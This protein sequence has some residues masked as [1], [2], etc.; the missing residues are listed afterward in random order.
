MSAQQV[1][2]YSDSEYRGTSKTLGVGR[3]PTGFG[4]KNDSLSSLKIPS[5]LKVTLCEHDNFQGRRC[6]LVRDTPNLGGANDKA[7]SLI[8]EPVTSPSVI[9]Y[10][11]SDFRGWSAEV[12]VGSQ[13]AIGAGND[14]VSS[15][16]V[17][18]GYRVT[19]YEDGPFKGRTRE[20][21]ADA[22]NLG[23]F[24]DRTSSIVVDCL[25]DRSP[26]L[27]ELN[28]II[29]KVG[30]RIYLHPDDAFG[31]SSVEWFLKRATLH[32]RGGSSRSADSAP[33]P[34]GGGDD[35]A[36]WLECSR[37]AR[38]GDLGSAVAY[39]NAKYKDHW[40]DIQF[41]IFYPYNGAG[42]AEVT[43]V[44][45]DKTI[46]LE[47]MGQHGGDWEHVTC[48]V[49]P[50]S[51]ELRAMYLAQHS[52]GQWLAMGD[53]PREN[54]R[55][56]V[57]SSRHGHACYR[58]EGSNLSNG[59]SQKWSGVT[60]FEFGLVNS[61][62]KGSKLLD[63]GSKYQLLRA[64]FLTSPISAPDWINYCRRWGPHI[65]YKSSDL[66]GSI[67][68][69]LGDIPYSGEATDAIWDA[70]PDEAKEENGPTGPWRKGAWSGNE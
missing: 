53:I 34:A 1:T 46:K 11:D 4:L 42:K 65:T 64:D 29:K 33:L 9:V 45:V 17:P 10:S 66:K 30:P 51:Q 59:T 8:I 21:T 23:D 35:G 47:P 62:A 67:R 19:L 6:I 54:G 69:S 68:S 50:V 15:V 12:P 24:N 44:D 3:Y 38:G 63:C 60:W 32:T 13:A 39:V 28:Q 26:T 70:I 14:L 2:V 25:T 48:R 61:T 36:Y 16:I 40:L 41:W 57:F 58:S 7:T 5:G 31:P 55:P 27:D 52:G 43:V 18:R 20:L 56:V 22:A 37:E 49:E